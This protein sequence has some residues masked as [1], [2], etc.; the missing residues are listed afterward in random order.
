MKVF[1]KN[2]LQ[3]YGKFHYQTEELGNKHEKYTVHNKY[4]KTS[5]KLMYVYHANIYAY[6]PL[7]M[8]FI[9]TAFDFHP[10]LWRK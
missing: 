9:S 2:S 10:L 7:A 5:F 8:I 6:L 4:W 1:K 3:T